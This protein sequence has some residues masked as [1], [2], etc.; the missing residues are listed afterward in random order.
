MKV[1]GRRTARLA[2]AAMVAAGALVAAPGTIGRAH[3]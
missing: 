1:Q 3:V 2:V